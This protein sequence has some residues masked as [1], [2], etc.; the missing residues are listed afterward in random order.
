MFNVGDQVSHTNSTGNVNYKGVVS[1][2]YTVG[3]RTMLMV[4][5]DDEY[6]DEVGSWRAMDH[7]SHFTKI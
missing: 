7:E 3:G 4:N 6:K 1:K 2:I 5:I